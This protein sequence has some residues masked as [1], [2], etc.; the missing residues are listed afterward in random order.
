MDSEYGQVYED[1]YHRHWWFRVRERILLDVISGLRLVTPAEI[2]DVG[3]GHGLFFEKLGAYGHVQGIEVDSSLIPLGS[4]YRDR[5]YDQPLGSPLYADM[6]FNLITALDVIEHIEDD[7]LAVNA[8]LEMLHPRGKLVVTVPASMML[9]D[10]HDVINQHY[11][12]Y[13]KQTLAALFEGKARIL[14]LRHLFHALFIPKLAVKTLNR[15]FQA[16]APQH[17]IPGNVINRMMEAACGLEYWALG[18]LR[19]PFGTS[20]LAVVEKSTE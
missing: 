16:D 9:W 13:S 20:L 15:S 8:M 7:D 17:V 11:R 1:L 18:P 14:E 4:R 5:I 3:C 12:R 6:R 2:L 10:R 19:I